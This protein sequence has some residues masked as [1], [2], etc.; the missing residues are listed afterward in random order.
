MRRRIKQERN[1]QHGG[2]GVVPCSGH[3]ASAAHGADGRK[4][5]GREDVLR[6]HPC[7]RF[8]IN[9]NQVS[10]TQVRAAQFEILQSEVSGIRKLSP[11]LPGSA[12][13]YRLRRELRLQQILRYL[14]Q[15]IAP[16]PILELAVAGMA[17]R[18][19]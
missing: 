11:R 19:R 8:P 18:G 1:M 7:A 4:I 14:A 16:V 5:D 15:Q 10:E 17:Q 2:D 6:R 3:R 9:L 12:L 13:S